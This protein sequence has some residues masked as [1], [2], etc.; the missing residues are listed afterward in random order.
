MLYYELE[1]KSPKRMWKVLFRGSVLATVA[2]LF[3]GIFGYATFAE[4]PIPNR[5]SY[6]YTE[7]VD[8]IMNLQ[9]ILKCPYQG[10]VWI[11]ICL[12]GILLVILFATPLN[13]LP[14]KDSVEEL[15]MPAG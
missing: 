12:F 1:R 9:N 10:N 7:T 6:P 8:T 14:C 3:G 4:Y 5:T 15:T 11:Y 2:Y 13:V